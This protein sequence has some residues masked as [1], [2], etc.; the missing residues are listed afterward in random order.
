[1][2]RSRPGLAA[3]GADK[4]M[5]QQR[6]SLAVVAQTKTL[7]LNMVSVADQMKMLLLTVVAVADKRKMQ[8]LNAVNVVVDRM[9]RKLRKQTVDSVDL[10]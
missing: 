3:A 5:V 6:S 2:W 7:L 9:K 1:M 4:M 10:G 8:R